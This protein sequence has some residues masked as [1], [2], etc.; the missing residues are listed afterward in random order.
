[1]REAELK[2]TDA[3]LVPD[4]EGWFVLPS[5]DARWFETPGMGFGLSLTGADGREAET[6]F[7]MLGMAIRVMQ[8][9][10]PSTTYHWET[11]QEDF[12]VLAGEAVL[13][14]EG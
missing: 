14:V 6:L 13:I 11:E 7:P 2:Q 3:G 8:P 10:L 5:R 9:G 4:S 12:P 1:M